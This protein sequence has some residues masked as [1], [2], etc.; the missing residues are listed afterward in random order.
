MCIVDNSSK[1]SK[2]ES[3]IMRALLLKAGD[4]ESNPGPIADLSD[5]DE[6]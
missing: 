3:T 6:G 4:V 5:D 1:L 2:D